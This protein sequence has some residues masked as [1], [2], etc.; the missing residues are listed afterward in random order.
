MTF[1]QIERLCDY[2]ALQSRYCTKTLQPLIT[3]T[4]LQHF[5]SAST[6]HGSRHCSLGARNGGGFAHN[7]GAFAR[8]A[9]AAELPTRT[10]QPSAPDTCQRRQVPLLLLN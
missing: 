3:P 10:P 5:T 8:P 2:N 4:A 1:V 7:F 9:V 6:E